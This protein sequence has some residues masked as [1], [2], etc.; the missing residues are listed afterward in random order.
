MLP[1]V[2]VLVNELEAIAGGAKA[3]SMALAAAA[4]PDMAK[5]A[6]SGNMP[7]VTVTGDASTHDRRYGS[8]HGYFK[9]PAGD[10]PDLVYLEAGAWDRAMG[11]LL[12]RDFVRYLRKA[13]LRLAEAAPGAALVLGTLPTGSAYPADP[14][15]EQARLVAAE[16]NE[17]LKLKVVLCLKYTPGPVPL[18]ARPEDVA[19]RVI[20]GLPVGEGDSEGKTPGKVS[21][22]TSS[23]PRKFSATFSASDCKD[24][25]PNPAACKRLARMEELERTLGSSA[26]GHGHG[27]EGYNRTEA[28][29]WVLN[30][31]ATL[32]ALP[33]AIRLLDSPKATI[34]FR[35]LHPAMVRS[36][37]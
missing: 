28:D 13:A 25:G 26:E 31:E 24:K 21:L 30:R 10:S 16:H 22:L 4:G 15:A 37:L 20:L 11:C 2:V 23:L 8:M 5:F 34:E 3:G 6:A 12:R 19:R 32:L 29:V 36:T 18:N 7:N 33:Q 1:Q 14:S 17:L 35:R 9:G 27:F